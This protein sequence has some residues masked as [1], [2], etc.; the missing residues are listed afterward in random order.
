[1]S[2]DPLDLTAA[3]Y[4]LGT[5]DPAE[6]AAF[7]M[8]LRREE[9]DAVRA[10]AAWDRR[11]AALA[12]MPDAVQPS[13]DLRALIEARIRLGGSLEANPFH[14]V[15]NLRRSR[16]RWRAAAVLSGGLAAALLAFVAVTNP[17]RVSD[18]GTTY[19]AAVNRGG[20]KPALIVR[21][22]LKTGRVFVRPIAAETPAGHALELWYIGDGQTPRSMGILNT[23]AA[24]MPMPEGAEPSAK[25]TFAVSVEPEGGSR[26]GLPTGP[27]TY[28]GHLIED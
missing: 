3:E 28:S 7:A 26:T 19:V 23:T 15:G 21:V 2:D 14:G 5:L 24:S 12:S 20:D 16:N 22:D 18:R 10:V 27:V 6:R 4:A 17:A 11:L 25:A 1:M 13:S 9:P 8:R